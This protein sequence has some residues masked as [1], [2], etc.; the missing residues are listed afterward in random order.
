[1]TFD[2]KEWNKKA[3]ELIAR[4]E[5]VLS[6][7]TP[8]PIISEEPVTRTLRD[9]AACPKVSRC[10]AHITGGTHNH[11]ESGCSPV[12]DSDLANE[13]LLMVR[14]LRTVRS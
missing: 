11:K 8:R 1:M 6:R 10:S 3:R 13:G 4:N 9:C 14:R 12:I 5:E 7:K 2:A